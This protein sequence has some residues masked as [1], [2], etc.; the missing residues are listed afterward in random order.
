MSR[1]V[2]VEAPRD[3]ACARKEAPGRSGISRCAQGNGMIASRAR[4]DPVPL[5]C[6]GWQ[7]GIGTRTLERLRAGFPS[8]RVPGSV[9]AM[10]LR[11]SGST[12]RFRMLPPEVA[13]LRA[14]GCC[15]GEVRLGPGPEDRWSYRLTMATDNEWAVALVEGTLTVSVPQAEI[16]AW[17]DAETAIALEHVTP[18]GTRIVVEKDLPRGAERRPRVASAVGA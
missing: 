2:A 11:I 4:S 18:W 1:W 8:V 10:K 17:A 13:S 15:D 9:S 14:T 3:R 12:V 5:R 16:Q 6:R 7:S